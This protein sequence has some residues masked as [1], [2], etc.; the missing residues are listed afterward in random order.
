M[1]DYDVYALGNALVDM[2]FEVSSEQLRELGVEKGVMTL[3]DEMRQAQIVERLGAQESKRGSGGSAAN[4]IIAVSQLGGQACFSGRVANDDLGR[5][6]LEDMDRAG[7]TASMRLQD[8]GPGITGKCLVLLTP[9]AD[10]TMHTFLGVSADLAPSDVSV[11]VITRSRYVYVEGYLV[12]GPAT[13]GAA[14][15]AAEEARRHG[16]R[17]ALSLSDPNIVH[18]FRPAINE[19]IGPGVDLLFAN[20]DEARRL[21]ETDDLQEACERIK[22]I[23]GQFVITRGAAGAL[24]HDGQRLHVID[25]VPTQA[26]DTL[27]AGDMFAGVFLYGLTHGM[28]HV[29]AGQL[30]SLAASRIV[31][32]LGPRLRKEQMQR[33]L[34]DFQAT[35]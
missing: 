35:A 23:A 30:A 33:V 18:F 13:R 15:F 9:D 17:L 16:V 11:E 21:G 5:F 7:V 4:T 3:V 22:Q 24:V 26:I 12:T 14:I 19:L 32:H 8:L 27:G 1:S 29:R 25:P 34:E 2:E 31:S 6:Y 28:D 10:R 20:E